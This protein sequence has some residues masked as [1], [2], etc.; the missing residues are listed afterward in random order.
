MAQRKL[1]EL[2]LTRSELERRVN[3][4]DYSFKEFKAWMIVR[5]STIK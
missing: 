4:Q 2:G 5:G 3:E 1:D